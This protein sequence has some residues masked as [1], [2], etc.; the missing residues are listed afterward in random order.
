M[1]FIK[2]LMLC[3]FQEKLPIKFNL[4]LLAKADEFTLKANII[5]ELL[6]HDVNNFLLK[7]LKVF[8]ILIL[9]NSLSMDYLISL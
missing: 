2:I 4:F 9:T 5:P 3:F 1:T 7:K 6:V 8:H